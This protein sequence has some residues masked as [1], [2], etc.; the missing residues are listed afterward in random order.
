MNAP[1][2]MP[3]SP[4]FP[5]RLPNVGTTIFTVMSALAAEKGAVNLG[6]G[7]PDFDCD[8]RI[9]DA[10]AAAMRSGH[11]Q[12]PPMAGVAPLRE[13]IADKIAQLYG[14]RYDAST[15][16]TVTAGATQALLTAILCAVHPGD[17]VIVV[18]PTYDSYLP[19][20]ELAGGKPVFVTL[21]APDYTIP[22]D[23][24]A[25]AITPNTRMILINTPHNPTGTVWREADMRKLEDI[26]R[27]TNVLILSDEV[28]EHMVYDGERHE[29]VARYPELA[30]RSFIVSSFG[31][32]YHVTGW[33]VGYVA[34]PAA[35]TAEF[36][37]VHQFNVFTVNT[38]MQI[39]LAEYL[40]DPAPYLTLAG[41]Y[42]NKRD[43][44]RAGL[45][46]TR[47]KLLPCS[48]T[49]FQC[50]DYSAISDLPEA[51][52]SKW[53][54]SEIGVAAI[55]V[56]AFYHEPHESGVVRFC[57]AKQE[58]TLATALERLARL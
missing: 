47:F 46:R 34:A 57:F 30:A 23:R 20:I 27:G 50:V 39:G 40:R 26:V 7:F 52:F 55:P 21:E 36:R 42:Q 29:S 6:Q 43:F 49:Y 58:S 12:Y 54:T 25:A 18:E 37:K 44:F 1:S 4:V 38:P 53:L 3:T 11:N 9:V 15:E 32:T 16:I 56:S 22:F 45:E 8:P 14:R 48:G 31:K 13:A 28:Y 10:V 5:S 33:K 41:F 24:L 35:L 51:E 19:S 17:E 2:D